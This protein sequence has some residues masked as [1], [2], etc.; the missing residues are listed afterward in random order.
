MFSLQQKRAISNQIQKILRDTNHEELP[1]SEITFS[2]HVNGKEPWSWA[3]IRNNGDVPNP[4]LNPW[5]E[6]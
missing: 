2:L 3:D 5:N 4:G 1:E 6:R